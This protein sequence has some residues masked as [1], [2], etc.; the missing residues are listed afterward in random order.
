MA[1]SKLFGLLALSAALSVGCAVQTDPGSEPGA[2]TVASGSQA[3]VEGSADALGVVALLNDAATDL[4]VLDELVPLDKRAAE[5]LIAHRNGAD[6]VFGTADDDLFDDVAE[7]DGVP[8]VGPA[9]MA[10]LLAYAQSGGYVP[11]G[12]ELLGTWD[13]VAFSV[14][15]ANATLAF[16]NGASHETLD[17]DVGLDKRA[18]DSIV[19]AGNIESI[20]QLSELYY[21]GHSALLALREYPKTL[22]GTTPNG[23]E[24]DAHSECQSGL[25]AGLTL[26]YLSHGFCMESWAANTFESTTPLSISD[27]GAAV[28]ST[29]PVSGLAT[30]PMD[31]V[32]DLDIDHPRKQDLVVVLHQPGG[33][34]ATL[35]NHQANPPSHIVAPS[36]IEGDNMV[37]GDWVLEIRDTVS[38][39]SG[40][41]KSW[42]MWLSSN[43]D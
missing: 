7:V 36:G 14:D 2:G 5:N 3:I 9:A 32:V 19:A 23:M 17:I 22:G 21:V 33:A 31:V 42:K 4:Y 27:D 6:G 25:C 43:W 40:T 11:S 30:V 20:L 18:A 13:N 35:W 37:N 12:S 16:V 29:L 41:L 15:E 26:P 24:C 34:E 38:G 1:T 8:W 39:E 28:E 10:S